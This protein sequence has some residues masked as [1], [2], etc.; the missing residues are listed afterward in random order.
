MILAGFIVLLMLIILLLLTPVDLY[1]NSNT[2]N[3]YI[4]LRGLAKASIE[5]DPIEIA[6]I[7]LH[8]FFMNFYFY[9]FKYIFSKKKKGIKKIEKKSK[10]K[11][12]LKKGLQII[13][14]FK[15]KRFDLEI[16]TGD[17][18]LNAK[19][20]PLFVFLNYRVGHF[21]VNFEDKNQFV[22]HLQNRPIDIIKQLLT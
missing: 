1:L 10:R 2:N 9:P 16:D 13:K 22:L 5:K 8:L 7:K 4:Q 17:Y 21:K 14:S 15:V 3:Y 11:I 18:C 6:R 12:G 19:L 20:Y